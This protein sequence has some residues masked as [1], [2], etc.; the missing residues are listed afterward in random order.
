[1][2]TGMALGWLSWRQRTKPKVKQ[3]STAKAAR[4]Q[5]PGSGSGDMGLRS[6]SGSSGSTISSPDYQSAGSNKIL[7]IL[8]GSEHL[9]DKR[10]PYESLV[11]DR[12]L[13][14][15][16]S[17]EVWVCSY[18]GRQVAAKR[19]LPRKKHKADSVQAF[20][21]EIELSA[22]LEHPHVVGFIGVAWNSLN[23]LAMVL[24]YLPM[25][26]LQMCLDKN[27]ASLSW[28]RDKIY[29]AIGVAQALAYLHD[30]CP[31]LI[32]RDLKSSNI[33]LTDKLE[34]K[35]IDFGISRDL[36]DL[37]MTGGVGTPYWTAPEV[38][39]GKHY[40]EQA[41]MYSLGVVLSEL[42]TG[43]VPYWDAVTKDG[44]K[45]KPFQ[46]LQDVMTGT[47]SP[48]F[49]DDCPP[50]IR[51][52]GAACLSLDPLERPSAHELVKELEGRN[53]ETEG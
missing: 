32:H 21:E 23:N 41:D 33:L 3:G 53:S 25:G 34:P 20:A 15:G 4:P 14:K 10:L 42:D 26:S 27:A 29:M 44:V 38:L 43:K 11:F 49:A 39:E 16:A 9:H 36:V 46:I 18:S 2:V 5:Y 30:R 35:L 22:S 28:A 19:L 37:T 31:P 50:R 8:L 45:L 24:E 12:V 1:V 7:Q 6:V 48:T 52:L 47:L 51:R 40:T 17:G 13:S